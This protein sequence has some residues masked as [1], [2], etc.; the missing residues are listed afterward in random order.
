MAGVGN[1]REEEEEG[2][3]GGG[4]HPKRMRLLQM[5]GRL[6]SCVSSPDHLPV[7]PCLLNTPW[8]PVGWEKLKNGELYMFLVDAEGAMTFTAPQHMWSTSHTPKQ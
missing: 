2:G 8:L 5:Q 3:G 6:R 4:L 7:G 1:G